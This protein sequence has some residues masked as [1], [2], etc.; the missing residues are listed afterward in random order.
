MFKENDIVQII[1]ATHPWYPALMIVE[2]VKV[3]GVQAYCLIPQSNS[4]HNLACMYN[5]LT[6]NQIMKVGHAEVVR[7]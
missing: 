2:E 7:E 4:E 6:N 1:D 3:W 5:R